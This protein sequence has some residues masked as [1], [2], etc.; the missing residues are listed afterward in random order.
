MFE[1]E[2]IEEVK[3]TNEPTIREHIYDD[4]ILQNEDNDEH[5]SKNTY[6]EGAENEITLEEAKEQCPILKPNE[7]YEP[8]KEQIAKITEP[9]LMA[10]SYP[11]LFPS[12]RGCPFTALYMDKDKKEPSAYERI[13]YLIWFAEK[14]NGKLH[15]RFASHPSFAYVA[16]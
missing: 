1:D 3:D 15:Y 16:L 9:H 13:N 8:V 11:L 7:V 10:K 14:R 6:C 12:G 2:Q 4:Q 5:P